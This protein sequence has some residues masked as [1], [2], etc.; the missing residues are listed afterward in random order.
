MD[1]TNI[2]KE[3]ILEPFIE[4]VAEEFSIPIVFEEHTSNQSFLINIVSDVSE[5]LR[6]RGELRNHE[7]S[8]T[9]DYTDTGDYDFKIIKV[10]SDIAERMK[11]LIE[12][13]RDFVVSKTWVRADGTWGNTTHTWSLDENTYCW[14]SGYIDE[15]DYSQVDVPDGHFQTKMTFRCHREKVQ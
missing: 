8:I 7:I 12:N 2:F 6:T 4:L 15:I 3:F 1:F 14:N 11:Q 10:L 13:S 5:G 9:Y